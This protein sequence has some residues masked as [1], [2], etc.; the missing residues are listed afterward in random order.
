MVHTLRQDGPRISNLTYTMQDSG[1]QTPQQPLLT[2]YMAVEYGM[3]DFLSLLS[4]PSSNITYTEKL[5]TTSKE[6]RA[7]V[8]RAQTR[9]QA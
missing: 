6:R 5:K 1:S 3:A 9:Y 7:E 2:M 4:F 8:P